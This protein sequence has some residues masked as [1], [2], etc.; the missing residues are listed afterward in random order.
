MDLHYSEAL[1]EY[2]NYEIC[3]YGE[4]TD[5]PEEQM[6]RGQRLLNR[7]KRNYDIFKI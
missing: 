3:V 1:I 6:E 4:L 2:A 5:L 7:T